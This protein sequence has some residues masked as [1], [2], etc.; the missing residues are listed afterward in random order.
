MTGAAVILLLKVCGWLEAWGLNSWAALILLLEIIIN[1]IVF[2]I[3]Y[4]LFLATFFCWVTSVGRNGEF[5]DSATCTA[6]TSLSKVII[7][8][9]GALT[10]ATSSCSTLTTTS[11]MNGHVAGFFNKRWNIVAASTFIF[12]GN[13]AWLWLF[14][15]LFNHSKL[16]LNIVLAWITLKSALTCI[17]TAMFCLLFAITAHFV[18]WILTLVI[19]KTRLI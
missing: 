16:I 15:A 13:W 1:V 11:F 14:R 7:C 12:N 19:L 8:K 18:Q 4:G 10:K 17:F 3:I 9:T 6:D 2:I 5:I